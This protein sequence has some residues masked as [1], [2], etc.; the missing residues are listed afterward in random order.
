MLKLSSSS[1]FKLNWAVSTYSVHIACIAIVKLFCLAIDLIKTN[2]KKV[3]SEQWQVCMH[4]GSVEEK[5][6]ECKAGR[7]VAEQDF[8][9]FGPQ[10]APSNS[11]SAAYAY[12]SGDVII[13]FLFLTWHNRLLAA[14]CCLMLCITG[15][16]VGGRLFST[17]RMAGNFHNSLC[18]VRLLL[19]TISLTLTAHSLMA[20]LGHHRIESCIG[21]GTTVSR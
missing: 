18:N 9:L 10:S 2:F 8:W 20:C 17:C 1:A 15:I 11:N 19:L 14:K 6:A 4:A 3:S 21:M 16:A 5:L 12:G 7:G 13:Y